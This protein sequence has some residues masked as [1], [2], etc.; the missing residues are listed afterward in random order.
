MHAGARHNALHFSGIGV[1]VALR[2]RAPHRWTFGR[3]EHA[4]LNARVI[5]GLRHNAAKRVNFPHHLSLGKTA[6]RRIA[7]HG[8]NAGWIH[9]D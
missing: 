3:V 5:G 6:N 4:K 1:L 9:G 2:A 7:T 8:A